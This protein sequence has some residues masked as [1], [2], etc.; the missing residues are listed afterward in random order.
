MKKFFISLMV[1]S[2]LLIGCA[3]ETDDDSCTPAT[4]VTTTKP[5]SV[6]EVKPEATQPEAKPEEKPEVKE[7]KVEEPAPEPEP[8]PV[9]DINDYLTEDQHYGKAYG[10]TAYDMDIPAK[11]IEMITAP[12]LEAYKILGDEVVVTEKT[13]VVKVGK[14][15]GEPVRF[16]RYSTPNLVN[17]YKV[18]VIGYT[19]SDGTHYRIMYADAPSFPEELA[20][21]TNK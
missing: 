17:I 19:A 7:P 16:I 10:N 20:K 3:V 15:K 11:V 9:Y 8:E 18:V 2:M 5:K 6:P 14:Y 4:V 1:V 12:I 13:Q 21:F